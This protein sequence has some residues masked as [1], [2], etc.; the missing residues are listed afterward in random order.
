[1]SI[2][3]ET[4]ER[5]TFRRR[6]ELPGVELRTMSRSSSAWFRYSSEYEFFVPISWSGAVWHR[7]RETV[8]GPGFVVCVQPGEVLASKRVLAAG[9]ACSLMLDTETLRRHL[10]ERGVELDA[11]RFRPFARMSGELRRRLGALLAL[12]DTG[13]SPF[14]LEATLADFVARMVDEL[15][16]DSPLPLQSRSF[17]AKM[18]EQ[19]RGY[20]VEDPC[21]TIDLDTLARQTGLSRFQVVRIFKRRYGLPPHSYQLQRRLGFAQRRLREGVR[22]AQVAIEFGFVDQSH[23]TRH[24]KRVFGA[25]PAQY[26]RAAS[27]GAAEISVELLSARSLEDRRENKLA[28]VSGLS[29]GRH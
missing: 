23:L 19:I 29:F 27:G 18:A 28:A 24:F 22:P 11:I 5:V 4:G 15:L 8:V 16:D 2:T 3:N 20:L 12:I 14:E 21:V 26:A 10:R 13:E 1:M 25:T 6:R 9:S 17:A 7:R